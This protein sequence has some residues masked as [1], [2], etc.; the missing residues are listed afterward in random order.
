MSF[1]FPCFRKKSHYLGVFSKHPRH[2]LTHLKFLLSPPSH[3]WYFFDR[4]NLVENITYDQSVSCR[5]W[6]P[7]Y[8]TDATIL[9]IHDLRSEEHTSELQSRFDLVCR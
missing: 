4:E 1:H 2:L 7:Q 3:Q 6:I 9:S 5:K 8:P